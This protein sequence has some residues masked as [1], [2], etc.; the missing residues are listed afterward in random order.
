MLIMKGYGHRLN[1]RLMSHFNN[2]QIRHIK[3]SHPEKH[4]GQL[5]TNAT[6][7]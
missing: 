7:N 2:L 5:Q 4:A 1:R 6:V 3:K